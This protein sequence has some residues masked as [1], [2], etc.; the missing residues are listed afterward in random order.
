MNAEAV[1]MV[2]LKNGT[3]EAKSLVSITRLV[4][5]RLYVKDPM[6]L[7][8]LATM[9]RD[10]GYTPF[11]GI[12]ERLRALNLVS[13]C[14]ETGAYH[15]HRSIRNVVL[16]AVEGEGLQMELVNPAESVIP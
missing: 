10:G 4:L 2:R 14:E 16:S 11:G 5:Q 1:Q 3:E 8:D 9:C 7:V 12:G 6:A 15:V 13:L